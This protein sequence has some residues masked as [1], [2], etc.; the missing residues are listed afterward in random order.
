MNILQTVFGGGGQPGCLSGRA[1][2]ANEACVPANMMRMWSRLQMHLWTLLLGIPASDSSPTKSPTSQPRSDDSPV[3][4][5]GGSIEGTFAVLQGLI[6]DDVLPAQHFADFAR[7]RGVVSM[8]IDR[9]RAR[10]LSEQLCSDD[11]QISVVQSFNATQ[12]DVEVPLSDDGSCDDGALSTAYCAEDAL[13][14]PA[15]YSDCPLGTD[16]APHLSHHP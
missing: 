1:R 11:C 7:E 6:D 4:A 13:C 2:T 9:K 15:D 5:V 14:Q 10:A 8:P 3:A 12:Y 16:C